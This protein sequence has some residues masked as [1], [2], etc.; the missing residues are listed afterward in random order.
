MVRPSWDEYFIRIAQAVSL[1]G[2]CRRSQVGAVLVEDRTHR[3]LSTGYN[4]VEPGQDGCLSGSCPRGRL[5]YNELPRGGDYSNCI[6]IHAEDNC[7][8]W[9]RDVSRYVEMDSPSTLTI[10]VTREPCEQCTTLLMSHNILRAVWPTGE[11]NL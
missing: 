10:Y 9:W 11:R 1:R 7:V 8:N 4:G 3:I 6:G 2:D 5:S